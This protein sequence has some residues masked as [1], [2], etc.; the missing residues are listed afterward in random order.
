MRSDWIINP[1]LA[2]VV[3]LTLL[4][5]CQNLPGTKEQQGAVGGG[6]AGAIIGSA[7]AENELFGALLGGALGA[8]GGYLIGANYERLLGEKGDR[9]DARQ[10]VVEASR[11]PATAEDVDDSS[12][13]DLNGDGFVTMDEVIA[14]EE[15]GLN[16]ERMIDRLEATEQVF[17]LNAEQEDRLIEAGVS[18]KVVA[19]MET[20]N[21]EKRK[22]LL[23]ERNEIISRNPQG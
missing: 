19:A 18:P 15:A 8:A 11:N 17:V 23:E 22:Q 4:A 2:G 7:L 12:T 10:A 1:V 16:N 21:Q 14:M 9:E 3:A 6:A 20:I 5:G 13:A